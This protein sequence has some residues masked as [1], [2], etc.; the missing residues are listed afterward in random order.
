MITADPADPFRSGWV[1]VFFTSTVLWLIQI[2]SLE[3]KWRLAEFISGV[4]HAQ[5]TWLSRRIETARRIL[6]FNKWRNTRV[7]QCNPKW[8][9]G[10]L[11][12]VMPVGWMMV[13]MGRWNV[14]CLSLF[15]PLIRENVLSRGNCSHY[16]LQK[17]LQDNTKMGL[18]SNHVPRRAFYLESLASKITFPQGLTGLWDREKKVQNTIL[19]D[20]FHVVYFLAECFEKPTKHHN[21]FPQMLRPAELL[22]SCLYETH[23]TRGWENGKT[24]NTMLL[25]N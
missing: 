4:G 5:P 2:K 19:W 6:E 1:I 3:R 15:L 7:S 10:S 11:T 13:G 12:L 22:E 23:F 20:R 21:H 25:Y 18:Y 16:F 17:V 9:R 24:T 8:R 14:R